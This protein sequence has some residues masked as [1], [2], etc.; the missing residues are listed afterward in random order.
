[1]VHMQQQLYE[2]CRICTV[3]KKSHKNYTYTN[4]ERERGKKKKVKKSS[5]NNEI[6][7]NKG[8]KRENKIRDTM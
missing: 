1:M 2:H 8:K 5:N 6:F 4:A 7:K 3:C